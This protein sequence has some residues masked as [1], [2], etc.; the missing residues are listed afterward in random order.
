MNLKD[1]REISIEISESM[2][3]HFGEPC[4]GRLFD[5]GEN[6]A[7]VLKIRVRG[8]AGQKLAFQFAEYLDEE[9]RIN[10]ENLAAFYPQNYCQRDEYICRGDGE[11]ECLFPFTYH[12]GRWCLVSGLEEGQPISLEFLVIHADLPRHGDFSCSDAVANRL[13]ENTVRSAL[14][15]LTCFPTDCPH[16]EKNG[17]TGDAAMSCEY[18][19]LNFGMEDFF[20]QWLVL[21]RKAQRED[22]ALPALFRP[23]DGASHG[24]TVPRGIPSSSNCRILRIFTGEIGRSLRKIP[25]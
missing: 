16:R 1:I 13:Q 15:N 22:G 9:N 18:F 3:L 4:G 19:T 10:F 8:K 12:G 25:I 11:E 2:H 24:G 6:V 23:A 14:S 20:R 7:G 5:F 17:W 21:A